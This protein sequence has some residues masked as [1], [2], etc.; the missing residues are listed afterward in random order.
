MEKDPKVENP[1]EQ[2]KTIVKR[3]YFKQKIVIFI[4]YN[5][6]SFSGL[7]RNPGVVTIEEEFEKAL[8]AG[9]FISEENFGDFHKNGWSRAS[10]TDKGVHAAMN[11]IGVK[12]NIKNSFLVDEVTEEDKAQGKLKLKSMISQEKVRNILN[13]LVHK[14]IRVFG[15]F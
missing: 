8:H 3:D 1:E 6:K 15:N 2:P 10:R 11:A 4:G 13:S 9:G 7:Q 12:V 14:D 5:G